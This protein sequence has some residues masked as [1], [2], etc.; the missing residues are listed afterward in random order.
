[1]G[2]SLS[3]TYLS[4]NL[5]KPALINGSEMGIIQYQEGSGK[6]AIYSTDGKKLI[7]FVESGDKLRFSNGDN[8]EK[9]VSESLLKQR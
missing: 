5:G 9:V 2:F 3:Q 6:L 4:R 8:I 7:R 1:M